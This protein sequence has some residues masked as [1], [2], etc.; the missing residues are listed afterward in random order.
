VQRETERDRLTLR[1][2]NELSDQRKT[3]E[4]KAQELDKLRQDYE[5]RIPQ[6]VQV[7]Q[8]SIN[9]EF[10]DIKTPEDLQK[11]AANDPA[12]Y[13]QWD[14]KQ[15]QLAQW[16]TEATQAHQRQ[17]QENLQRLTEWREKQDSEIEK[18][19]E[20]TP[21]AERDALANE[22]K[23]MLIEYGLDED[24]IPALWESS[25]LRASWLV[26][27]LGV[28]ALMRIAKRTATKPAAKPVPPVQKPGTI[29]PARNTA[30]DAEIRALEGKDNLKPQE[31]ARLVTLK[32]QRRAAA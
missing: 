2:S 30:L 27:V 11:L 5:S 12:R 22:A 3:V 23:A 8:A 10:S 9:A 14:A 24:K 1:G 26:R 19:F 13:I 20:K 31:A 25:I 7:I 16:Q 15:K 21:K 17:E 6:A 4:A 28:A 18:L 29:T 32:S